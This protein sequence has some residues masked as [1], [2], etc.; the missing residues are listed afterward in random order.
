MSNLKY[1]LSACRPKQ[2][3]KN[4]LI[5]SAPLFAFNF[6]PEIWVSST[7]ALVCFCII[8]SAIYLFNDLIDIEFDK[9]HPAKSK[10]PIA[11]GLIKLSNARLL[12]FILLSIGIIISNSI[13]NEFTYLILA[14]IIIQLLYNLRLKREPVFDILCI[15]S[16]FLIRAISGGVASSIYISHWFLLTVGFLSIFLAI[17]KRKAE[18]RLSI[19]RGVLTREVLKRYSINLLER[20]EGIA[21]S[22]SIIFYSLWATGSQYNVN[23][24]G[25][26]LLTIPLVI[27]GIFRYQLLSDP[28]E[29]DRRSKANNWQ[30]TEL[31][32]EILLKDNVIRITL[33]IWLLVIVLI[34]LN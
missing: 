6:S 18:L 9:K 15:S 3:T 29:S 27:I 24:A 11:A 12:N 34:N 21:S 25:L 33:L 10:R 13:S 28:T 8:S 14:Y 20:M 7:K 1:T 30:S 16:G 32:E 31:P 5:Y 19:S 17:E 22:G 4:L 23:D 26:M 2:W